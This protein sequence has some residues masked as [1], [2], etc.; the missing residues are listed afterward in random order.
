MYSKVDADYGANKEMELLGLIQDTFDKN[1]QHI[2]TKYSVVDYTSDNVNVEL[3]TRRCNFDTYE[4]TMNTLLQGSI[5]TLV[6]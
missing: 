3:K 1:I 2:T 5:I 4:D 6:L